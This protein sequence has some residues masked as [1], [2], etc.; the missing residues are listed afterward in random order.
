MT[1]HTATAYL[2]MRPD[3]SSGESHNPAMPLHPASTTKILTAYVARKWVN[4]AGLDTTA[5]VSPAGASVGGSTANLKT[6]DTLTLNDL[7]YGMM[8]PS[9]NDA[10]TTIAEYVG[11][12]ILTAE[13]GTGDT[14]ARFVTEMN[15]TC[16]ALGWVGATFHDPCGIHLDNRVSVHQLVSLMRDIYLNDK[17]LLGVMGTLTK[18]LTI[19]GPDPRTNTV[20]LTIDPDGATKL[21]EFLAGKTG[22]LGEYSGECVIT[23]WTHSNG[24]VYFTGILGAANQHRF[25]ELRL[26]LDTAM[27]PMVRRRGVSATL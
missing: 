8:L 4:N 26:M 1:Y 14:K 12:L 2:T 5:T 6:G 7:F 11:G 27:A 18:G 22:T 15:A 23:A 16:A 21:P 3:G 25:V 17:W 20:T 19:T 24:E 10:A 9:G 13:S